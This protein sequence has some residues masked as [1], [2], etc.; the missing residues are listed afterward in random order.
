[1]A[2][3]IAE[4]RILLAGFDEFAFEREVADPFAQAQAGGNH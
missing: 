1:M 2:P 4:T 3:G